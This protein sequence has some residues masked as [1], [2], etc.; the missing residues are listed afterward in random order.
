[1]LKKASVIMLALLGLTACAHKENTQEVLR[2]SVFNLE[3]TYTIAA[4]STVPFVTGQVPG[5][6]I[7]PQDKELINKASN[8]VYSEIQS[9]KESINE[10]KPLSVTLVDA[11]EVDLQS[12]VNCWVSVKDGQQPTSCQLLLKGK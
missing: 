12:F 7:T 5:V 2:Q 4:Q 10:D 1:M 8:T 11:V 3:T 9:L 6:K